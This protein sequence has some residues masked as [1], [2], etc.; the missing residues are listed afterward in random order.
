MVRAL[1]TAML[2][3]FLDHLDERNPTPAP[4]DEPLLYVA[5]DLSGIPHLSF[6]LQLP[7]P[8]KGSEHT[9]LTHTLFSPSPPD[10]NPVSERITTRRMVSQGVE[11]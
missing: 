7:M 3:P 4:L 2:V 5:L 9:T 11:A 1:R 8:L 10:V 6:I